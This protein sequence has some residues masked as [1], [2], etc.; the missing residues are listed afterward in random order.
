VE[1]RGGEEKEKEGVG[2]QE[3]RE[4]EGMFISMESNTF[5]NFSV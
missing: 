5:S 1:G 3:M 2:G 4:K